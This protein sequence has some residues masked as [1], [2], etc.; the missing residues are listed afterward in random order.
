MRAGDLGSQTRLSLSSSPTSEKRKNNGASEADE[1]SSHLFPRRRRPRRPRRTRRQREEWE[2]DGGGTTDT[3]LRRQRRPRDIDI[4][5][6]WGVETTKTT[7][8]AATNRAVRNRILRRC[9]RRHR[10][11]YDDDDVDVDLEDGSYR[12]DWRGDSRPRIINRSGIALRSNEM[13][14]GWASSTSPNV[15]RRRRRSRIVVGVDR[16][17]IDTSM[18][19]PGGGRGGRGGTETTD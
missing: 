1:E 7:T 8:T 3:S 17:A 2:E 13:G 6:R 5:E 18:N 15:L 14:R 4:E 16:D 19:I 10:A 9:H 11:E 12:P